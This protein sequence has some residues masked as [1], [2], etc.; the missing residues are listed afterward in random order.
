MSVGIGWLLLQP[1]LGLTLRA[2]PNTADNP[3][4]FVQPT[5]LRDPRPWLSGGELVLTTGLGLDFDDFGDYVRRLAEV[6]VAALGFGT[7]LSYDQIPREMLASADAVGLPLLEV[8]FTTP[9]AAVGRA[10]NARLAEQ[11]YEMVRRA[12]A[13]QVRITRAALRGGVESI[14]RELA[15]ATRTAVAYIDGRSE[16]VISYPPSA[17]ELVDHLAD[18]GDRRVASATFKTAG[19]TVTVQS[20]SHAGVLIGHLVVEASRSLEGVELVLIGHALSLVTLELE[21]LYR[22]RSERN[23]LGSKVFS[24]LL[25]GRLQADEAVESLADAVGELDS[26]RVLH[27]ETAHPSESLAALDTAL[28]S[29][30]RPLYTRATNQFLTVILSGDDTVSDVGEFLA[31]VPNGIRAGLSAPERL[32]NVGRALHQA[33]HALT[34]SSDRDR[35]VE[36]DA[37]HGTLL[38]QSPEVRSALALIASSTV[39]VL[40]DYD[41]ENATHLVGS[42]RAFLE[43]NGHWE[44]AAASLNV[45]RHT[46]RGRIDKVEQLLG[47]D[48]AD[49]RIRAEI[50]LALLLSYESIV[51]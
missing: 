15:T 41:R 33:K 3:I 16:R 8:P 45:H 5:E 27:I 21:K 42:L 37:T 10:V 2:G 34:M 24:L 14:V 35:V 7:G 4:D 1:H 12:S 23:N 26:I 39:A 32:G 19:R 20:V 25:D 44:A 49:A 9:F 30:Q 22:L 28:G 40:A 50:L 13:T 43:S 18:L 11:E 6:G 51:S 17:A 46:L 31:E 29:R 48:L 38:L 47:I 36:F